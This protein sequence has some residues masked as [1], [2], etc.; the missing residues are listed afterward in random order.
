LEYYL[1]IHTNLPQ[2]FYEDAI[3]GLDFDLDNFDESDFMF[4]H[5][6]F[7]YRGYISIYNN[8]IDINQLN[9]PNYISS[10]ASVL[11]NKTESININH[12]RDSFI[13]LKKDVILNIRGANE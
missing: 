2:D 4:N 13:E 1:Y 11:V 6:M 5:L 9:V 10:V 12:N 3:E 8:V 7:K